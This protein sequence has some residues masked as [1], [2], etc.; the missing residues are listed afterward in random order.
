MEI[1][2]VC[3]KIVGKDAGKTV[4]VVDKIDNTYVLI[5]GNVKRKRCNIK[6]LEPL[7]K[8]LKIE[9]G[10]STENLIKVMNENGIE[11]KEVKENKAHKEAKETKKTKE[12]EPRKSKKD[13]RKVFRATST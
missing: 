3:V 11:V 2:R 12:D 1:G 6:H 13:S 8:I 10:A 4:I 7:H 9:K 5:D